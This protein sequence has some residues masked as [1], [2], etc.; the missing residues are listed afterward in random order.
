MEVSL[1]EGNSS[2]QHSYLSQSQSSNIS[3]IDKVIIYFLY[4]YNYY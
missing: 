4:H 1:I 2:S 3:T